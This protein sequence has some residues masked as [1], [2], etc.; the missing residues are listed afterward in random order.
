[1]KIVGM[2]KQVYKYRWYPVDEQRKNLAQ[3][4]S[5]AHFVYNF[6]LHA[7]SIASQER[8]EKLTYHNLSALLPSLKH[9]FPSLK[10]ISS[11]SIQQVLHHLETAFQKFFAGQA[12]N[13]AFKK[14]QNT[15]SA[16]SASNACTWDGM[17]LMLAKEIRYTNASFTA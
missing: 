5:G 17:A 6:R 14:Q 2:S 8:G 9:Q 7:R 3:R 1:M 16:T 11:V 15:Q 12:K 10:D 4:F 13:P